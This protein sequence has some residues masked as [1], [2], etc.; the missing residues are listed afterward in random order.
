[1][2]VNPHIPHN[3]CGSY[4]DYSDPRPEQVTLHDIALSLSREARYNGQ[5]GLEHG[6]SVAQHSVLVSLLVPTEHALAGLLHDG[7]EAYLRDIATPAKRLLPDY[8]HLEEKVQGAVNHAFG[9][10]SK[11]DEEAQS[12]VR[13]ADQIA[14]AT[15]VAYL[16]PSSV[17]S[18]INCSYQPISKSVFASDC[19]V[20]LSPAQAMELFLA[21]FESI[22]R[23]QA[24]P[25]EPILWGAQQ[26]KI[27]LQDASQA[28]DYLRRALSLWNA[29][30]E[31]LAQEAA[32]EMAFFWPAPMPAIFSGTSLAAAFIEGTR[33]AYGLDTPL[34]SEVPLSDAWAAFDL[35]Q[36]AV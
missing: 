23:N 11:L 21:R 31:E 24:F 13:Q 8:Q 16:P 30:Q 17:T 2:S 12:L 35:H 32:T 18:T 6:Y 3:D 28:A 4:L 10:P 5:V 25:P 9:L 33:K 7:S 22:T 26:Y 34:V 27:C 15:E 14:L 1:M 19:L 20:P 36:V 29:G